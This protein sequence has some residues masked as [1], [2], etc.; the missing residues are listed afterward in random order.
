M[1]NVAS[2]MAGVGAGQRRMARRRSCARPPAAAAT[3]T[4]AAPHCTLRIRHMLAGKAAGTRP[5]T[6]LTSRGFLKMM[7]HIALSRMLVHTGDVR[8]RRGSLMTQGLCRFI[9][10]WICTV[11]W[12]GGGQGRGGGRDL[13]V[14]GGRAGARDAAC[15]VPGGRLPVHARRAAATRGVSTGSTGCANDQPTPP[16]APAAPPPAPPSCGAS[17]ERSPRGCP[18]ACAP[19][20]P[21]WSHSR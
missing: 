7:R 12:V 2:D 13:G 11:G 16:P 15:L 10:A 3:A 5:A 1:V 17:H 19:C 18:S 21:A 9:L 6:L 4:A 20:R 8:H 14:S